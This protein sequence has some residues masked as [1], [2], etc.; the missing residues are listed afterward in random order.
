MVT[1]NLNCDYSSHYN[2]TDTTDVTSDQRLTMTADMCDRIQQVSVR[3]KRCARRL[4]R[5]QVRSGNVE[6]QKLT[7]IELNG[8]NGF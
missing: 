4:R 1:V 7:Q 5:S 8:F 3:H 2:V 6:R